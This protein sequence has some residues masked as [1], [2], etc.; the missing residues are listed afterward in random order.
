MCT[1]E[2]DTSGHQNCLRAVDQDGDRSVVDQLH[3]HHRLELAG[4][5]VQ[6]GRLQF[7]HERL[8]ERRAPPLAAPPRR[9]PAADP[10]RMSP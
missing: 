8:V 4:L 9:R 6:A 10:V 1:Q 5:D 2:F 3:L 7:S